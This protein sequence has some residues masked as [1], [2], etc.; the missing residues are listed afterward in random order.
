MYCILSLVV[1]FTNYYLLSKCFIIHMWYFL[2][3]WIQTTCMP[4]WK[5]SLI[6][7][8][9]QEVYSCPPLLTISSVPC[10]ACQTSAVPSLSTVR[11]VTY[12][13]FTPQV[14]MIWSFM[15][16]HAL[17]WKTPTLCTQTGT[18]LTPFKTLWFECHS[19]CNVFQVIEVVLIKWGSTVIWRFETYPMFVTI[20][21]IVVEYIGLHQ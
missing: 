16:K 1:I 4:P 7:P 9:S 13:T 10:T 18:L 21:N 6:C 15:M 3:C 11:L 19:Q 8:L 2:C 20:S 17:W 5:L 12:V 14:L